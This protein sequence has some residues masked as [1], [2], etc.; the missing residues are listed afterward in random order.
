MDA[1]KS[2]TEV[3]NFRFDPGAPGLCVCLCVSAACPGAPGSLR[4][5][6]PP[7]EKHQ[8]FARSEQNAAAGR[9]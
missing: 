5:L 3:T 1:E 7:Y 6:I 8:A 2:D 4:L 9:Q